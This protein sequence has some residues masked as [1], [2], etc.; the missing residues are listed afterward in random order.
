MIS[1]KQ[2]I[3]FTLAIGVVFIVLIGYF[4]PKDYHKYFGERFWTKK[5]F[6]KAEYDIVVLGD[7]RVYR[8]IS[9]ACFNEV[10]EG[11]NTLNFGYSNGGL[12]KTIFKAAESKLSKKSEQ[13]IIVLGVSAFSI[14]PLSLRNSQ[15]LQELTRPREEVYERLYLNKHLHF[16]SPVNPEQVIDLLKGK[17]VDNNY[18][19]IYH[20]NGW[21][22]SEKIVI[23]TMEA[24]PY[25]KKDFSQHLTSY[26]LVSDLCV[27]IKDWREQGIL[28]FAF[29]PPASVPLS[30]LE[31]S[32]GL[33]NE[34]KISSMI[35]N[36][37]AKW[38]NVNSTKYKTYDGSH[39]YR[40]D[41]ERLSLRI[42]NEIKANL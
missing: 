33:Y 39:L 6:A 41:A 15:Y 26:E 31:D 32:V 28:V 29:R 17:K 2:N 10:L 16:F 30:N 14:N 37:G 1:I 24:M 42:A 38:I 27:Q 7:S 9:P 12:N 18:I 22:E 13:K 20:D 34:K 5:V 35:E 19:S 21:V 8:G 23:D 40:W 4:L 36:A 25:Y 3:G 11:Y